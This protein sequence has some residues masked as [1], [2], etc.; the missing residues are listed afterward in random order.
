MLIK[1]LKDDIVLIR[2]V[3]GEL[4]TRKFISALFM[5][6]FV[7]IFLAIILDIYLKI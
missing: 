5:L 6:F 4:I 7:Q 1:K 3:S 2:Q